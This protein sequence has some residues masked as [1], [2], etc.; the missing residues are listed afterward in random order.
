[1]SDADYVV[2]YL[3]GP[4]AGT[5]GRRALVAGKIE[6]RIDVIAAVEG[7]ESI[8]WYEVVEDRTVDGE[9]LATYRFDPLDSDPVEHDPIDGPF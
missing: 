1:M 8:Y 7:L 6:P 9:I 4:M 2:Q 3:D 5:S